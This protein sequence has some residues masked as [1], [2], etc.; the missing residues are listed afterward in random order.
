MRALSSWSLLLLAAAASQALAQDAG[1]VGSATR[2]ATVAR[3]HSVLYFERA[4]LDY[5]RGM[6]ALIKSEASVN[7]PAVKDQLTLLGQHALESLTQAST[8]I[9]QLSGVANA[10]G[11]AVNPGI[12]NFGRLVGEARVNV[13][14]AANEMTGLLARIGERQA[15]WRD[16]LAQTQNV[17]R[18]IDHAHSVQTV[19]SPTLGVAVDRSPAAKSKSRR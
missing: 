18:L 4:A 3:S 16:L 6:Q 12:P 1:Q 8:L 7:D 19:M 11:D 14:A 2:A 9:D 17:I 10:G 13:N 5:V 15:G